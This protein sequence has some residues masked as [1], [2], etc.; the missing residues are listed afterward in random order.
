MLSRVVSY[1]VGGATEER[2]A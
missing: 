2:T 1:E